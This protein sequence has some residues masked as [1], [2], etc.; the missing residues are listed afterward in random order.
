MGY[1]MDE[2]LPP[3][4][5]DIRFYGF[6]KMCGPA[7]LWWNP[8]PLRFFNSDIVSLIASSSFSSC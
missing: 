8:I 5:T 3:N 2:T 4:E 1:T 7:L 6:A